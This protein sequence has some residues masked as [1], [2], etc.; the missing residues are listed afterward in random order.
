[1]HVGASSESPARLPHH[2]SFFPSALSLFA[3][4]ARVLFRLSSSRKLDGTDG[5][6]LWTYHFGSS[7]N[8]R[9]VALTIDS[10]GDIYAAGYSDYGMPLA[11]GY[12]QANS[13]VDEGPLGKTDLIVVKLDG[14]KGWA[15]WHAQIGSA[16]DDFA[17]GI[18][19]D[20]E[21]NVIVVG[22][23]ADEEGSVFGDN[24]KG[25]GGYGAIDMFALKLDGEDG[26]HIWSTQLG[27]D[28]D[29]AAYAVAASPDG[30]VFVTG[31]TDGDFSAASAGRDDVFVLR[32]C[33]GQMVS[34]LVLEPAKDADGFFE[35][36]GVWYAAFFVVLGVLIVC[37]IGFLIGKVRRHAMRKAK[38]AERARIPAA[39]TP[40]GLEGGGAQ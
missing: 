16:E 11:D 38:N 37:G 26:S 40:R 6:I 4:F 3:A 31:S 8:D 35:G 24:T 18:T 1:M 19:V 5:N 7:A 25:K 21:G 22:A 9:L 20:P 15:H 34:S 23:T 14:R 30:D 29:D 28:Q 33:D 39:H 12:I 10:E 13:V 17:Y 36:D 2:L 27:S 32:L